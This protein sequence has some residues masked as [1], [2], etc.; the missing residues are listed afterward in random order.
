MH[1][2]TLYVG[3]LVSIGWLVYRL[4]RRRR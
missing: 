4:W 2:G 1:V 3:S